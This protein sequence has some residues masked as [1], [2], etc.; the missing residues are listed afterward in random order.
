VRV[1]RF[2]APIRVIEDITT[3]CDWRLECASFS[4]NFIVGLLL[5]CTV[6]VASGAF[7]PGFVGVSPHTRSPEP[8]LTPDAFMYNLAKLVWTLMA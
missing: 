2:R 7:P 8:Q 4:L 3:R 5:S 6:L 1:T